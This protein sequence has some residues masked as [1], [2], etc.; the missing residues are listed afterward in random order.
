MHH[1]LAETLGQEYAVSCAALES[2]DLVEGIRARVV[3]K[4]R[5]PQWKPASLAEV[6][7]AEVDRHFAAPTPPWTGTV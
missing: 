6:T 2:H 4:D 1:T 7:A 3:D 5:S